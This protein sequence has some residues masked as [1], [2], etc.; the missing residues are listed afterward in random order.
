ME[1]FKDILSGQI[2]TLQKYFDT[3]SEQSDSPEIKDKVAEAT[4]GK[5]PELFTLR[6]CYLKYSSRQ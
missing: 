3:C 6:N 1:T 4:A 5:M 2:E